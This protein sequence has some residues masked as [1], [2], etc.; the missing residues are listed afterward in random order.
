MSP[1]FTPRKPSE[2]FQRYAD[3]YRKTA[4]GYAS[5]LSSTHD[6]KLRKLYG[7]KLQHARDQVAFY[8]EK[9]REARDKPVEKGE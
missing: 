6:P 4:A 9:A 5:S 2:E 1:R 8:E 7:R 3:S